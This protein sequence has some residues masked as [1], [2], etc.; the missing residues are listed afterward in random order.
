MPPEQVAAGRTLIEKLEA[1]D[2]P[3]RGLFIEAYYAAF[4][5]PKTE[6]EHQ[7]FDRFRVLIDAG[8]WTDAALMLVPENHAVDLTA[9]GPL[10]KGKQRARILPLFQ[11]A[12]R[13]FHR[14]SD[15]DYCVNAPTLA[16]ALC[17]AA[18]RAREQ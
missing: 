18:L 14:G 17:I 16:L 8:G 6:R 9:W 13:W 15:P 7:P 4:G 1:A 12:G 10:W 5:R 11:E 3:S 2:G